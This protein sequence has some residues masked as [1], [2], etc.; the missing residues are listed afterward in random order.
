MGPSSTHGAG[1]ASWCSHAIM[2]QACNEGHGFPMA[3]GIDATNRW[4]LADRPRRRAIF[5]FNPV[6]STCLTNRMAELALTLKRRAASLSET[7]LV[8]KST[9]RIRKSE[10]KPMINPPDTLNQKKTNS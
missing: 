6:S 7:P 4:L 9:I 1:L 5:V 2:A 3:M 8:T 10:D